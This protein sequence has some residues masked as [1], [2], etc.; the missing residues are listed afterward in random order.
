MII[1]YYITRRAYQDSAGESS[2]HAKFLPIALI[3]WSPNAIR[4]PVFFWSFSTSSITGIQ[5]LLVLLFERR[6]TALGHSYR[7]SAPRT[8]R[9]ARFVVMLRTFLLLGGVFTAISF[10]HSLAYRHKHN[11]HAR[12]ARDLPE[13][14]LTHFLILS[15]PRR[16]NSTLL[17]STLQSYVPGLGSRFQAN[18]YTTVA[19]GTHSAFM[20]AQKTFRGSSGLSFFEDPTP[21][22]LHLSK[23]IVPGYLPGKQTLDLYSALSWAEQNIHSN[24]SR[25]L[26]IM[27]DD[28]A[29]C[30]AGW[31]ELKAIVYQVSLRDVSQASK[32]R[33]CGIFVATGGR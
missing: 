21:A 12:M 3:L 2:G 5:S 1:L 30:K 9:F 19:P 8:S 4:G 7:R 29:W 11:I 26:G 16:N 14:V 10:L 18:V 32:D 31:E 17:S 27:E 25:Y 6:E 22:P 28:F 20:N 33:F 23:P 15:Y 24:T 13:P